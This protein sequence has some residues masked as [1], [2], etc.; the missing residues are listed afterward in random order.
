MQSQSVFTTV[1]NS[2]YYVRV[3]GYNGQVGAYTIDIT[4]TPLDLLPSNDNCTTAL[5]ISTLPYTDSGS[6]CTAASDYS[7]C[8][9]GGSND[10]VYLLNLDECQNV[11]VSTCGGQTNYDTHLAVR[12]DGAC[13][14]TTEIGCNDDFCGLRSS[15]SFDAT[16]GVTYYI[17][18]AGF[19]GDNGRYTLL[20][21]FLGDNGRYTLDV[22]SNGHVGS[23]ANDNCAGALAVNALPYNHSGNTTCSLA[24]YSY[25]GCGFEDSRDVVYRLNLSACQTVQVS[26]CTANSSYDT[27]IQVMA[28][29]AC[30]GN[31]LVA[32][33]DDAC[34]FQSQLTFGALA[35]TDYFILVRGF[36]SGAYGPYDLAITSVGG[37]VS[38]NDVCPGAAINAI[39]YVGY[40]NTACSNDDYANG[41]CYFAESSPEDVYTLTLGATE[42]VVVTL[43]GSG[44]DTGLKVRTGGACPGTSMVVCDDDAPAAAVPHRA[45]A[46]LSSLRKHSRRTTFK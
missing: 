38:P 44:Y 40:G 26:T 43:C 30:P 21:G 32:C 15:I 5:E 24:D 46:M 42:G 17:I 13:P 33:N 4:E 22:T 36:W 2:Y 14:G 11:T 1:P 6:T 45:I 19:L 34:G 35:N 37:Y 16:A 31:T 7:Y 29:G 28:G 10:V 41:D 25:A 8:A 3:F 9:A 27:R 18:L 23:P 20:A 39:P 12:T